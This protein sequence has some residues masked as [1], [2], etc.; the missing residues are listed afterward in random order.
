[1]AVVLPQLDHDVCSNYG[2]WN[3][4]AGIGNDPRENRKFN[5]VKQGLD[6]DPEVSYRLV[7]LVKNWA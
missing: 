5:M 1:M 7:C 3:Y 6:Y 4:S 2:N